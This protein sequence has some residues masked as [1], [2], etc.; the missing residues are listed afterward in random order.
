MAR[1][2]A[3]S[4]D[5][6]LLVQDFEKLSEIDR[7]GYAAEIICPQSVYEALTV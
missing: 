2:M 7:C 1:T 6:A 4:K 3:V 5:T